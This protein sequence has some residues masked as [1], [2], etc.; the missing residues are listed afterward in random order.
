M[1]ESI[2]WSWVSSMWFCISLVRVGTCTRSQWWYLQCRKFDWDYLGVC[3]V[4]GFGCCRKSLNVVDA[5]RGHVCT[6]LAQRHRWGKLHTG[7]VGWTAFWSC[8]SPGNQR[9]LQGRSCFYFFQVHF[10]K[11]V[12]LINLPGSQL[13]AFGTARE[14]N[15]LPTGRMSST[16]SC[17]HQSSGSFSSLSG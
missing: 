8:V 13:L 11:V 9:R 3:D 2:L 1:F 12:V 10:R 5:L 15:L 7:C 6:E 14:V 4:M 16:S 17:C